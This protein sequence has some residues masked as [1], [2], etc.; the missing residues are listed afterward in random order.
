[1]R[2]TAKAKQEVRGRILAAGKSLFKKK[3]FGRTTTRD[4]SG[5]AGI[6]VGTLFNYF[7]NKESLGMSILAEAM[8]RARSR[9]LE[10]DRD[11]PILEEALFAHIASE[12]REMR[13]YRTFVGPVLERAMSPFGSS[14]IIDEA[15][16]AR[17]DHLE[18]VAGMIIDSRGPDAATSAT[19]HLYW[20][21]YLG[22]LAFWSSD[23]SP[24]QEDTLAMLDQATRLFVAS[25]TVPDRADQ[26]GA[27]R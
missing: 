11:F 7:P 25:L 18:T 4:L 21:L 27:M 22:V 23:D 12:L 5:T 20:S 9:F 17:Q 24:H 16:Q 19:L 14:R 13:P 3:G 26:K 15:E 8:S 2:I 6:A 1:M 10:D